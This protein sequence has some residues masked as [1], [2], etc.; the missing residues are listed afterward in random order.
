MKQ[1]S[2]GG[3]LRMLLVTL[4]AAVSPGVVG[5]ATHTVPA[6]AAFTTS[7]I[8]YDDDV[9]S[10]NSI[11]VQCL[12]SN[13][14]ANQNGSTNFSQPCLPTPNPFTHDYNWWWVGGPVIL[15]YTSSNCSGSPFRSDKLNIGSSNPN[16]WYCFD[17]KQFGGFQC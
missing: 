11:I 14:C 5:L 13:G 4:V 17:Y 10:T 9:Y 1:L 2:F 12:S 3:R 7:Q 8:G 6:A 16:P 15:S